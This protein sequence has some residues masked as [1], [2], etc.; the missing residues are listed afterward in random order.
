MAFPNKFTKISKHTCQEVAHAR[1]LS[2]FKHR[3]VWSKIN[4]PNFDVP[5]GSYDG[6]EICKLVGLFLLDELA[7]LL[8]KENFRLYC[9]QIA[10]SSALNQ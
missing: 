3:Y 6:A 8:G 1:K 10:Y 9:H 4:N 5:M 7:E 2:L